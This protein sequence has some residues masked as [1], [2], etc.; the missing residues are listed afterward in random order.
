M[1]QRVSSVPA[2]ARRPRHGG[3][4]PGARVRCRQAAGAAA[5]GQ[6]EHAR[7][8]H[9][10]PRDRRL[11]RGGGRAA[12]ARGHLARARL[13][14][15]PPGRGRPAAL[16]QPGRRV[17]AR[18]GTRAPGWC[19]FACQPHERR[20]LCVLVALPCLGSGLLYGLSVSDRARHA[21]AAH[22]DGLP[23]VHCYGHEA[24]LIVVFVNQSA[25]R[26]DE[27]GTEGHVRASTTWHACQAGARAPPK[28]SAA[29][30][31]RSV[32]ARAGVLGG[33][34]LAPAG[35][36][37]PRRSVGGAAGR[38]GSAGRQPAP[39]VCAGPAARPG[40]A[41]GGPRRRRPRR[42]AGAGGRA[43]RRR[44]LRC[45][46]GPARPTASCVIVMLRGTGSGAVAAV[47][48]GLYVGR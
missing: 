34:L 11:R 30:P 2:R 40:R 44:R 47:S 35:V 7:R 42:A 8:V 24:A 19:K 26:R 29:R 41:G 25:V 14:A 3:V 33:R 17:R 20:A 5:H 1:S 16:Q 21:W 18:A 32:R 13:P 36:I 43:R 31:P 39:R 10:R 15:L 27:D 28:P 6:L 12:H 45:G 38:P 23:R 4:S 9:R 46:C 37:Q 22:A 48:A